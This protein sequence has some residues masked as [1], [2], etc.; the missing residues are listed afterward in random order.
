MVYQKS[1]AT[2]HTT[3]SRIQSIVSYFI[4]PVLTMSIHLKTFYIMNVIRNEK[5]SC[6]CRKIKMMMALFYIH[7]YTG[8]SVSFFDPSMRSIMYEG[9]IFYSLILIFLQQTR[10][11][12]FKIVTIS[13]LLPIDET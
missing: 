6:E 9:R 11:T 4:F 7:E 12:F 13:K 5:S 8:N 3:K 10:I 1:H 2:Y